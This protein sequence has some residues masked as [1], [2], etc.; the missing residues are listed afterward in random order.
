MYTSNLKFTIVTVVYNGEKFIEKTI[1]SVINQDYANKEYIIIDGESKD[2]TCSIISKYNKHINTYISERD[3]GIYDAMNKGILNASGEW[4]IFMNAGDTFYNNFILKDLS[5]NT[6]TTAKILYGD[7]CV[8]YK[9]FDKILKSGSL[10]NMYKGMQF[11][12]Q[13][14]LINTNFHKNNLYDTRIK[15]VADFNFFYTSYLNG[16][17][18]KY[19]DKI[20]SNTITGGISDKKRFKTFFNT[21]KIVFSKK[22]KFYY[23][24]F[25]IKHF[26]YMI[27]TIIFKLFLSQKLVNSYIKKYK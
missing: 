24:F 17:E 5:D 9:N 18:F 11:S 12:H 15:I 2:L 3:K 8:K 14:T 6:K 4:I 26:F 27:I 1:L 10:S 16:I 25:F 7:V 13:S 22:Y 20:F 21:L 19:I 23:L